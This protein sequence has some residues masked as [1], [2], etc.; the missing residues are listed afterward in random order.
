MR[1][2]LHISPTDFRVVVQLS[3][4]QAQRGHGLRHL[5]DMPQQRPNLNEQHLLVQEYFVT[6]TVIKQIVSC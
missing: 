5:Q 6:H 3:V 4:L 2:S 1:R